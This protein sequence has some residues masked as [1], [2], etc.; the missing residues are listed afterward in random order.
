VGAG[1][2]VARCAPRS[3]PKT[4]AK[5]PKGRIACNPETPPVSWFTS[6]GHGQGSS[7]DPVVAGS[8]PVR[9][10][11]RPG[12]AGPFSLGE[13]DS[14]HHGLRPA[15]GHAGCLSARCRSVTKV[16]QSQPIGGHDLIVL[17]TGQITLGSRSWRPRLRE[18]PHNPRAQP[19]HPSTSP[20]VR[21]ASAPRRTHPH[22]SLNAPVA[23]LRFMGYT[24]LGVVPEPPQS[25]PDPPIR[26]PFGR[27]R[28]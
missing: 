19:H 18:P 17:P 13:S 3:G 23:P 15:P 21:H 20:P 4:A 26:G 12:H 27:T 16:G 10:A 11:S 28:R 9:L 6:F 7:V 22:T 2:L 25:G 8:S 5:R 14:F 24:S 1:A